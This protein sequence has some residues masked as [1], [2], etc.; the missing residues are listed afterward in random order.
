M[1]IAPLPISTASSAKHV[2]LL[3]GS[4]GVGKTTVIRKVAARLAGSRI[5]GF[6]TE[7]VRDR[8]GRR[9]GFRAMTFSG[10]E[11]QIADVRLPGPHRGARYGVDLR[12]IDALAQTELPLRED[13]D[14][15]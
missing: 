6:Y 3:T 13:V 11:R 1:S 14:R 9:T 10:K 8:A 7:E 2:L 4:P 5:A 15:Y 12:A